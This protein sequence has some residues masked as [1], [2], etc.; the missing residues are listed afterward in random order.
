[1]TM[2]ANAYK[3][4]GSLPV[5]INAR[6]GDQILL[7]VALVAGDLLM[8]LLG[9]WLAY[10]IRFE[11]GISLFYQPEI[12]LLGFYQGLLLFLAPGWLVIFRLFGLYDFKNLFAGTREYARVFN[13]CTLSMMLIIH[14]TFFEP[15]FVVARGW[16]VLS[17][18][19]IFL[20]VI[21]GRF[22]TRRFVQFMRVNHGRLM[23]GVLI[24]GANEEGLAIAQQLRSN[25]KTGVWIAGFAEDGIV[26]GHELLPKLPVLGSVDGIASLVKQYGVQEIIVT[27]SALER[28]KLVNLFQSVSS[29]DGVTLRLSAGLYELI[30]TGVEVQE[31]GNVPLLSINKMRLNGAEVFLKRLL[32]VLVAGTVL[33]ISWPILLLIA[34]AVKVDSSG[35]IFYRRRVI[36]VGG[37]VFDALKFRTMYVDAEDRLSQD[38]ELRRQFELNYKLK[39]D[40]R[41]TRVGRYLRRAS[42]DE[43]PQLVNVLLG[44][45][46]LIGPR[47]ITLE[48]RIRYGKWHMNLTTVKPGITGL[49]QVS[50]RSDVGYEERVMLDMHYIRNYSLWLDLYILWRTVPAVLKG[51]GAY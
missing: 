34:I 3:L 38:P 37:K 2:Q 1:M 15:A 44:Q 36:G 25:R 6:G 7:K 45:M 12:P 47:M 33:M 5:A 43:L 41:V 27:S 48:E 32:D 39:V 20:S 16:A 10:L 23:T 14:L 29:M 24:V 35:P 4:T 13:A 18:V 21:S 22:A 50:G 49:W 46:S 11:I 26:P 8:I 17:W 40:P 9:F 51:H 42:L 28:Q 31:V 19:L 30:T